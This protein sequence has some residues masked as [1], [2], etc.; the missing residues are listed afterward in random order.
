MNCRLLGAAVIGMALAIHTGEIKM[1]CFTKIRDK[2]QRL[3][4]CHQLPSPWLSKSSWHVPELPLHQYVLKQTTK[5]SLPLPTLPL[6]PF[7][8]SNNLLHFSERASVWIGW[9]DQPSPTNMSVM[10]PG[11]SCRWTWSCSA[12]MGQMK[13]AEQYQVTLF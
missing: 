13:G 4:I 2:A 12:S 1:C 6:L 8:S 9:A 10:A 11:S 7:L 5:F 3:L